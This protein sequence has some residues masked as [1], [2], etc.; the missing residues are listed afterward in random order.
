MI[1]RRHAI[2]RLVMLLVAACALS[3]ASCTTYDGPFEQIRGSQIDKQVVDELT[4]N[5]ATVAD[6]TGRLGQPDKRLRNADASESLIYESIK[7]RTS[8]ESILGVKHSVT[9]QE[10]VETREFVFKE[11]HLMEVK[12]ASKVVAPP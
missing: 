9:S 3:L 8:F 12:V 4:T 2:H 6:V 7:R 1:M 11:D 10:V 5:H